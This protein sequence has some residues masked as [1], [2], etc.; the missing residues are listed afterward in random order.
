MHLARG[1]LGSDTHVLD[2]GDEQRVTT[3]LLSGHCDQPA[4][5]RR[6]VQFSTRHG[7]TQG[8]C[9]KAGASP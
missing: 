4:D 5:A 7:V 6:M 1:Q 2:G 3:Y 9:N 8:H